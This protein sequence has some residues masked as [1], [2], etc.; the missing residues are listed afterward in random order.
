MSLRRDSPHKDVLG[1]KYSDYW[2]DP[3]DPPV[4]TRRHGSFYRKA[5]A[6]L[7]IGAAIAGSYVG[8]R[9]HDSGWSGFEKQFME[10]HESSSV[11]KSAKDV[12]APDVYEV[13]NFKKSDVI[14]VELRK[15]GSKTN[16]GRYTVNVGKK[17]SVGIDDNQSNIAHFKNMR[18]GDIVFFK[19]LRYHYLNNAVASIN[20]TDGLI[21]ERVSDIERASSELQSI[22]SNHFYSDSEKRSRMHDVQ[23]NYG[24]ALTLVAVRMFP[25]RDPSDGRLKPFDKWARD[26][27]DNNSDGFFNNTPLGRDPV[28]VTFDLLIGRYN[29]NQFVAEHFGGPNSSGRRAFVS[30]TTGSEQAISHHVND[31]G[32]I[33]REYRNSEGQTYFRREPNPNYTPPATVQPSP[34][35]QAYNYRVENTRTG[36]VTTFSGTEAQAQS[37]AQE[38]RVNE[39]RREAGQVA[40]SAG[41]R[42]NDA[43]G[44]ANNAITSFFGSGQKKEGR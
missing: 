12:L 1:T 16:D 3:N 24:E 38:M 41:Q 19:P 29:P 34:S 26:Y 10:Y 31:D 22:T 36:E 11:A 13:R 9:L 6:V 5:L 39:F 44:H 25:V 2:G 15:V 4:S 35:G 32:T 23:R 28:G 18:S 42:L 17:Y 43:A 7:G 37:K 40:N 30:G 33:T 27:V 8:G 21:L 14:E 20:G